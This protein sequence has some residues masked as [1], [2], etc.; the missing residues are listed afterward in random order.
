MM[1]FCSNAFATKLPDEVKRY[2]KIY[3]PKYEILKES[4]AVNSPIINSILIYTTWLS[5]PVQINSQAQYNTSDKTFHVKSPRSSKNI[6]A[7]WYIL[8]H[9]EAA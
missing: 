1:S 9:I 3:Y 8:I 2:I 4:Y 5:D 6:D 7:F